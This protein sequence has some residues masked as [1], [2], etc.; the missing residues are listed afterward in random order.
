MRSLPHPDSPALRRGSR[1]DPVRLA[2]C[3]A[4]KAVEPGWAGP[5]AGPATPESRRGL[6]GAGQ[7]CWDQALWAP[8]DSGPVSSLPPLQKAVLPRP[9]PAVWRLVLLSTLLGNWPVFAYLPPL[10]RFTTLCNRPCSVVHIWFGFS[11]SEPPLQR[12]LVLSPAVTRTDPHGSGCP[13]PP[14]GCTTPGPDAFHLPSPSS[15]P[16]R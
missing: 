8:S 5:T 2:G 11:L 10:G 15:S 7:G 3:K 12:E 9:M 16:C 1:P 6:R 13:G 14:W 4:S